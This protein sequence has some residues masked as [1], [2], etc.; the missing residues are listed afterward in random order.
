MSLGFSK[1]A[2]W[3]VQRMAS[4]FY[5]VL[6]MTREATPDQI[7]SAYRRRALQLH[8]DRSRGSREPS[9]SCKGRTRS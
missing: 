9:S 7:H 3:L 5:L 4:D 8:P 1:P 2:A 6:Q